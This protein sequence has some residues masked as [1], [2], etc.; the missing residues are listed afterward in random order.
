MKVWVVTLPYPPS[1]N[2]LWR[3]TSRGVYRT[4]HYTGWLKEAGLRITN[5]PYLTGPIYLQIEACPNDKRRRD[6]DNIIKPLLDCSEHNRVIKN[7]SQI[8]ELRVAWN[9]GIEKGTVDLIFNE[10]E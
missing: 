10:R 7:D 9:H 5:P 2:R 6:L 3:Y 1:V 4:K 8:V